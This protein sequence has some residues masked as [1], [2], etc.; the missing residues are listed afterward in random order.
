MDAGTNNHQ[1]IRKNTSVTASEEYLKALCEKTFLSLWSYPNIYRDQGKP[2]DVGS[3]KEICDLLVVFENHI[4]IFSDKHCDFQNN[5]DEDLNWK[6]WFNRAIKESAKQAW[7]AEKWIRNFQNRIFLD[8]NCT[9]PLPIDLPK[10]NEMKLHLVVVAHGVSEKISEKLGGSGSLMINSDIK[11]IK[12]HTHPFMIGDLDP[13]KTFIHVLDDFFLETLMS[14]RDTI[15]EFVKYLE[16]KEKLMRSRIVFAAGEEELLAIYLKRVKDGEHDFDLPSDMDGIA[17]MEG[18]WENFKS[19][20]QR[21]AQIKSDSISYVWDRLI[22]KFS[23][24]ALAKNQYFV[25]AG[26]IKDSEVY[27]T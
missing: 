16:K 21:L 1:S 24:H 2:K 27:G 19:H 25:S 13:N 11:G 14:T 20:P 23:K 22:E 6:R 5:E 8:K 18:Y 4:I 10:K 26:G 3:G 15:S 17:L 12:D 9:I 7:G